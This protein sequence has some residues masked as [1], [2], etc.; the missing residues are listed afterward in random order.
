MDL[1]KLGYNELMDLEAKEILRLVRDRIPPPCDWINPSIEVVYH[2]LSGAD[3]VYDY[4]L[5]EL[6][7]VEEYFNLQCADAFHA[8]I[9]AYLFIHWDDISPNVRSSTDYELDLLLPSWIKFLENTQASP[10]VYYVS[11]AR[12]G[13]QARQDLALKIWHKAGLI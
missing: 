1:S 12:S 8:I 5:H 7:G 3:T 6:F 4:I 2:Q 13:M 11:T 9:I 10:N